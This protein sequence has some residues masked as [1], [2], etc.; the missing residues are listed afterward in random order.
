MNV[1]AYENVLSSYSK[2]IQHCLILVDTYRK[3][4]ALIPNIPTFCLYNYLRFFVSDMAIKSLVSA[5]SFS[6]CF[7]LFLGEVLMNTAAGMANN[8]I[9]VK[10][11]S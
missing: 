10:G 6:I 9:F 2:V 4:P 11:M 7:S 1:A 5:F 8:T 3:I